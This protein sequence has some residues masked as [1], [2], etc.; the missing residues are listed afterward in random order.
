MAQ[1]IKDRDYIFRARR[2]R[3]RPALAV[4]ALGALSLGALHAG[5][6]GA[7]EAA[8]A[9][10]EAETLVYGALGGPERF[11]LET[12]AHGPSIRFLCRASETDCE[13]AA[14]APLRETEADGE[15]VL[16]DAAGRPVVTLAARGVRLHP[17]PDHGGS[18]VVPAT[19]P[20]KGRA[21]L[22]TNARA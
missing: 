19:V 15:T 5:Q 8:P 18:A 16:T 14:P 3:M 9:K 12:G 17:G 22:P 6:T 2:R 1:V 21:V 11:V 10:A 13:G 4:M 20:A 7:G